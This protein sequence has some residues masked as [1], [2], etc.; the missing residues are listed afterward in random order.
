MRTC[1]GWQIVH[2]ETDDPPFGMSTYEV[3]PLDFVVRWF[4]LLPVR[5]K[6]RWRCLPIFEGDVED[7]L[8]VDPSDNVRDYWRAYFDEED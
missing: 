5:E 4:A 3:Y 7:P 2:R 6:S 1:I 8:M